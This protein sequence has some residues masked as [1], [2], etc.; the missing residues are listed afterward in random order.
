MRQSAVGGDAAPVSRPTLVVGR[1]WGLARMRRW[2]S[3]TKSAR[4]SN[5]QR[6]HYENFADIGGVVAKVVFCRNAQSLDFIALKPFVIWVQ[7]ER[8]Y[9]DKDLLIAIIK[10][11]DVPELRASCQRMR[12]FHIA[13]ETG[14]PIA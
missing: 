9:D 3:K 1:V 14:L 6:V 12:K 11:F 7:F 2:R 10:R 8:R 13:P 4:R 5:F